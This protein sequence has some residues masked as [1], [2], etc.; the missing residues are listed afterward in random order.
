MYTVLDRTA[1][2]D[3]MSEAR[4]LC[5]EEQHSKH[6]C[7]LVY[8]QVLGLI[9]MGRA[10]KETQTQTAAAG[11]PPR[12]S[13]GSRSSSTSSSA[14]QLDQRAQDALDSCRA[15]SD[16]IAG[17]ANTNIDAEE[18]EAA[19]KG[20]KAIRMLHLQQ[21]RT[22]PTSPE[23][24][25][26]HAFQ[27]LGEEQISTACLHPQL[28]QQQQQQA[29][30][31]PTQQQQST[32]A[33]D[34]K[35]AVEQVLSETPVLVAA[36]VRDAL[37]AGSNS[38][39][40]DVR[41][42]Q[43]NAKHWLQRMATA[44]VEWQVAQLEQLRSS[45]PA[46]AHFSGIGSSSSSS[47]LG[48]AT[49][50]RP[51][52]P[53]TAAAAA[54]AS[55]D[56]LQSLVSE[57]EGYKEL[58]GTVAP[59]VGWQSEWTTSAAVLA[60]AAM[61]RDNDSQQLLALQMMARF[62]NVDFSKMGAGNDQ[63]EQEQQ[64][65]QQQQKDKKKSGST[66]RKKQ[67]GQGK[68]AST[69]ATAAAHSKQP[70]DCS[71][72]GGDALQKQREEED[73]KRQVEELHRQLQ[74]GCQLCAAEKVAAAA[75][76]S[77]NSCSGGVSSQQAAAGLYGALPVPWSDPF[78]M[79]RLLWDLLGKLKPTAQAWYKQHL[80]MCPHRGLSREWHMLVMSLARHI[81]CPPGEWDEHAQQQLALLLRH[82]VRQHGVAKPPAHEDADRCSYTH[83]LNAAFVEQGADA[84][85]AA[86][87][88]LQA[89][90]ALD[91]HGARVQPRP[92]LLFYTPAGFHAA[93]C[94]TL[95]QAIQPLPGLQQQGQQEQGQ[96]QGMHPLQAWTAATFPAWHMW[97]HIGLLAYHQ[98][99]Q[100]AVQQ[101]HLP[102]GKAC[103]C[104]ASSA[105][106]SSSGSKRTSQ[107]GYTGPA[108]SGSCSACSGSSS[109]SSS[110]GVDLYSS[111]D[112]R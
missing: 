73:N 8:V 76:G 111:P 18:Q 12:R 20:L 103:G 106:S 10:F 19:S 84:Q 108:V 69:A 27:L 82:Q 110:S 7:V 26:Q 34:I 107:Q 17:G 23:H 85:A 91:P 99:Q 81:W 33:D 11:D 42:Q 13:S 71:I 56:Q 49:A 16:A 89:L 5:L 104:Q 80:F 9:D 74:G 45:A 90:L 22:L 88:S 1:S 64:Q 24:W 100:A 40:P 87:L 66:T 31:S 112:A 70:D 59:L 83:S 39:R 101:Q 105:S 62:R 14:G 6:L 57:P 55:A 58:L 72:F 63:Q 46:S 29:T 79:R 4:K 21:M 50:A 77:S 95:M 94:K 86:L 41:D 48:H 93:V 44:Y 65:Q 54:A 61:Q 98:Q 102:D 97:W 30:S 36:A 78:M 52:E 75:L 43:A 32:A 60:A 37:K 51:A 47:R 38:P 109:S 15:I 68:Q 67:E 2:H 35:A 25:F 92:E 28:W 96:I 53:A 3:T